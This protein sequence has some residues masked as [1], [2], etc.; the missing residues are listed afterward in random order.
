[1]FIIGITGPSGAGKGTLTSYFKRFGMLA[2]DT[3]S[4]YH[5]LLTPPSECLDEIT[6][7]FGS[8]VLMTDGSLNRKA[9]ANIVF[10]KGNADKLAIL[11]KITHKYVIGKVHDI[12]R[13]YK[14]IGIDKC[15][16]DAPLLIESGLSDECDVV[17]SVLSNEKTRAE[18]ILE[19]DKIS[20]EMAYTRI[21]AQKPDSFYID[22]SDYV[23][24][25][26]SDI[27]SFYA[28]AEG[29]R[30]RIEEVD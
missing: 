29:L 21:K 1:M 19:R 18:R 2:I 20:L 11:N 27:N 17:I 5:K 28:E 23:I 8:N 10:Q 13:S 6:A 25:N 22:A 14:L 15:I 16:I 30:K 26:N 12:I 3:D 9:L 7:N 4:V 24:Y